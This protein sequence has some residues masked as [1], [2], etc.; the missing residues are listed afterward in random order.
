VGFEVSSG[1]KLM[2]KGVRLERSDNLRR[3]AVKGLIFGR[4]AK[5]G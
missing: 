1:E 5:L 3:I 4:S 2:G